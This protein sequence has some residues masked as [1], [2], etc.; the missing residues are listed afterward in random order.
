MAG[1]CG[2][3]TACCR[4]YA[5]PE[6]EKPAGKWCEHCAIGKGC[7]IYE[8]RPKMCLEYE[9]LWLHSQG[10]E[11]PREQ[12]VPEMRPDKCK[13]IFSMTTD[14]HIIVAFTA[15]GYPD[16][17]K[18]EPA[19]ALINKLLLSNYRVVVGN[20]TSKQKLMLD[21]FGAKEITLSEPDENGMQWGDNPPP[22]P[23]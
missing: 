15:T 21:K 23:A 19:R 10:R 6:L 2:S 4:A 18:K 8:A 17:W 3:C 20:P 13:V 12:M 14:Q 9:C 22:L 11:D 5:I 16:A 7:K 1:S